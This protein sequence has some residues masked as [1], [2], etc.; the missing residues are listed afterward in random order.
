M[1]SE[2]DAVGA[3]A[4]TSGAHTTDTM[5]HTRV[6][7]GEFALAMAGTETE[8]REGDVVVQNGTPHGGVN[9][10]YQPCATSAVQVPADPATRPLPSTAGSPS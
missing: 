9:R 2:C 7:S 5:E 8:S 10:S 3:S 1:P 6:V 4:E